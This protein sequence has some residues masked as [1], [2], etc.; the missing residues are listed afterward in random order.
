[1]GTK[2]GVVLEKA[3]FTQGAKWHAAGIGFPV[4]LQTKGYFIGHKAFEKIKKSGVAQNLYTVTLCEPMSL[5]GGKNIYR[6]GDHISF[7][8]IGNFGHSVG[9]SNAF[10][11][12]SS[13]DAN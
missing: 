1:M 6:D 2:D 4:H 10:G 8:T 12:I 7:T 3:D 11:Y 13:E 9:K 5:Y